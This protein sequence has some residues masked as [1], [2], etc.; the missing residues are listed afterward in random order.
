MLVVVALVVLMMTIL[1][2]IFQ[3]ATGAMTA[4]KATQDIDVNLR[5]ID[6]MIRADL[7]G[8]TA[9]M[10]PPNDPALKMGYF[11]YGEN[12]PADGQGE[13]TD[14]YLAFTVKAPEG[15]VFTARQWLSQILGCEPD[16]QPEHPTGCRH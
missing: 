6:S 12:S 4:S 5:Q 14:D 8:V 7:A 1:V 15:Q 13:D 10:T 2:Q 16:D 11:E 3:S 9:K